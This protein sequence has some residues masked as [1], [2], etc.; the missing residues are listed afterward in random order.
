MSAYVAL[1]VA[2]HGASHV[3]EPTPTPFNVVRI[4]LS[5]GEPADTERTGRGQEVTGQGGSSNH[6]CSPEQCR[7]V[8]CGKPSQRE[9][10]L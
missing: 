6:D 3:S 9:Q 4:D 1:A 7:C 2:C 8:E 10:H 5:K